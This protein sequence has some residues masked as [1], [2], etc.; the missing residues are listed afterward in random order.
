MDRLPL[1]IR[2]F[3]CRGGSSFFFYLLLL[4]PCWIHCCRLTLVDDALVLGCMTLFTPT[5]LFAGV[6]L[7]TTSGM[8]PCATCLS[9]R[10]LSF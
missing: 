4:T 1:S 10:F 7:G 2:F 3:L 8:T 6:Y 9:K 5:P